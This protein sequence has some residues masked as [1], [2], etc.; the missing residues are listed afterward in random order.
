MSNVKENKLAIKSGIWYTVANFLVRTVTFFTTPIFTRLLT[1]A[2]Y[3]DFNTFLSW[4]SVAIVVISLNLEASLLTARFDYKDDLERYKKSIV[5]LGWISTLV[6][7]ALVSVFSS[8]VVEKMQISLVYIYSMLLYVGFSPVINIYQMC[9][10]FEYRYRNSVLM[11]L[12]I[13]LGSSVLS[14]IL[15]KN[16]SDRLSGRIIGSVAPTIV[17]GLVLI[18]RYLISSEFTTRYWKYALKLCIPYIPHLLSLTILNMI[19]RIMIKSIC[20]SESTAMYSLAY[21]CGAIITMLIGSMNNAFAPWLGNRLNRGEYSEIKSFAKKYIGCF[22]V[23]AITIILV[24]PEILYI[25]GGEPYLEAKYV[26]VPVAAGCFCQFMY[27]MFVNV[28]QLLKKTTYM[29]YASVSAA[30]LNY[31]LNHIFIPKYGYIAA[32]YTTLIGYFWLLILHMLIV[33]IIG[34]KHVY[35][36]KFVSLMIVSVVVVSVGINWV[37]SMNILRLIVFISY[38]AGLGIFVIRKRDAIMAV[39][40]QFR[41]KE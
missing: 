20:G 19:D 12:A 5:C 39:V 15:V 28:E 11:G 3:G 33:R 29:A 2:E 6:W 17:I 27:T 35:D 36:Y 1:K 7:I 9:E 37:Y 25:L 22:T 40:N 32:A 41:K 38:V 18:I 31:V 26:M 30:V 24:G 8:F 10:R 14:V 4:Q 16:M 23:I 21:N 34:C 13:A